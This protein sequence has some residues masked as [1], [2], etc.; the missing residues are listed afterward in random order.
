MGK[1]IDYIT[2]KLRELSKRETVS[3]RLEP[4]DFPEEYGAFVEAVNQWIE[5][6]RRHAEDEQESV[7]QG[8]P[9]ATVWDIE[10]VLSNSGSGI[11]S[12][13]ME[14]GCEPKM[15]GNKTM[16]ML[17]GIEDECSPEEWYRRWFQNIEPD[18]VGNVQETVKEILETGF[19]EVTYLWNHPTRGKIYVRCGGVT[20]N[21]NDKLGNCLKGYHQDITETMVMKQKQDRALMEA[22]ADAKRANQAKSEF[23]SHMSH[24]IRTP[25]NG[26]LGMLDIC[27]KSRDSWEK[28]QECRRKIRVSAEH[29]LSLIND[30]LDISK[31]ESSSFAFSS[32]AFDMVDVLE[33]CMTILSPQAEEHG[34]DMMERRIDLKHTRLVG[35]PLHIRQILINIIGNAIKYNKPNG[36]ISVLTKELFSQDEVVHYQFV[37]EDTG[38]GMGEEYQKHIFEPFTQENDNARTSYMGAGLGMSI[39]KKLIDRM[40]GTITMES[41]LGKGT[42]FW[43]DL[44]LQIDTRPELPKEEPVEEEPMDI[45]G[46]HVLLVEDNSINCEIVEYIL[47]DAGASVEIAANGK[48]AVEVFSASSEG[49]FDCILMDVMMPVMNG[50]DA[51]RAIR[52]LDRADASKVPII[53]LSANAFAED[54]KEAK[55]AGMNEHLAKPIENNK[56]FQVMSRLRNKRDA[57]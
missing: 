29:L 40:G 7:G 26:I 30:V 33:S 53:A 20:D 37:I 35:S 16:Q 44:P 21:A 42:T 19:S 31:L 3:C 27:E 41:K 15:Y 47:E 1:E 8:Y 18:Y 13:E 51:T 49:A 22:L 9:L 52:A 6:G 5:K 39:T 45:S 14:E 34:L 43:V 54:I 23:L 38:L 46:M 32:E 4:E 11:W 28:Q 56:M 25:I 50:L 55:K 10:K 48:R 57:S 17:L 2:K 36:T 24:D 12:I